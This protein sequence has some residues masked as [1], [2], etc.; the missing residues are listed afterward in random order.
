V[1]TGPSPTATPTATATATSTPTATA[2]ATATFTPYTDSYSYLYTDAYSNCDLYSDPDTNRDSY[3]YCDFHTYAGRI[4][5][6]DSYS[7]SYT[8][9]NC[10]S[11]SNS[12]SYA[13]G[14][15]DT[16]PTPTP[17][18]TP[19][20]PTAL[21]ATN[22]TASSFNANWSS[23]SGA[24]GY[25]LDVSTSKSFTTYVLPYQNLDVGNTTSYDVIGLSAK[26]T[27]YYRLRALQWEWYKPNSNV[28]V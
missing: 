25:R 22:V 28:I 10:S 3:G 8:N 19:A 1:L 17:A 26:T 16:N 21:K 7:Y 15:A 13:Y 23:V 27:Y 9:C 20:A 24:T 2:T 6:A 14:D 12:D 5:D 18:P 11:D 4:T